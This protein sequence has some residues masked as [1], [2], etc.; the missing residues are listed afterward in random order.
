[1]VASAVRFA[2]RR[3]IVATL[4]QALSSLTNALLSIAVA[5]AASP[6]LYARFAIALTALLAL[7]TVARQSVGAYLVS[8]SRAS[9]PEPQV[10][11]ALVLQ[12]ALAAAASLG[13][14]GLMLSARQPVETAVLLA[15]ALVGPLAIMQDAMRYLVTSRGE[16]HLAALSDLV[17]L[18]C[19]SL[20]WTVARRTHHPVPWI[21]A[22]WGVG[23][24]AGYAVLVARVRVVPRLAGVTSW[25]RS[26]RT[27]LLPLLGD[28]TISALTPIG[29][30]A[31][32]AVGLPLAQSGAYLGATLIFGPVNVLIALSS[33]VLSAE[34]ERVEAR[35]R[36]GAILVGISF[37]VVLVV[38]IF[39][40]V[41]VSLPPGW[42]AALLG[43][44]WP[45]AEPVLVFRA[46]ECLALGLLSVLY[47]YWR[48]ERRYAAQLWSRL[49]LAVAL[50]LAVGLG[51]VYTGTARGVAASSAIAAGAV[52]L[53][54]AALIHRGTARCRPRR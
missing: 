42:G 8:L 20:C 18:V 9:H 38:G 25:W 34:L 27:A 14:L 32:I 46:F 1:M 30:V 51:C 6:E 39:G 31:V 15:L 13:P 10:R 41:V 4:D 49:G 21:I 43:R 29:M 53:L 36:A 17:W 3:V 50:V 40:L 44:T 37:A 47:V 5:R 28:G 16:A 35:R 7:L 52:L 22:S 23:A 45:L 11:S 24:V 12:S 33:F 48:W 26:S 2:S 54:S 19:F